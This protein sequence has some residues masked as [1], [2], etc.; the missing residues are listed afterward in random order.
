MGCFNDSFSSWNNTSD[1][2]LDGLIYNPTDG[3]KKV[4]M[5]WEVCMEVCNERGFR[6]AGLKDGFQCFCGDRINRPFA[7]SPSGCNDPCEGNAQQKCGT[8]KQMLV[9]T[10]TCSGVPK[11]GAPTALMGTC[12]NEE[13]NDFKW[14][15]NWPLFTNPLVGSSICMTNWKGHC[16]A[17][18]TAHEH[19]RL[20][21]TRNAAF[22]YYNKTGNYLALLPER[23]FH[24]AINC[25][26]GEGCLHDGSNL[27]VSSPSVPE[28][29]NTQFV[30]VNGNTPPYSPSIGFVES[31]VSQQQDR[32]HQCLTMSCFTRGQGIASVGGNCAI[33]ANVPDAQ[34]CQMHC[35]ELG[36][37]EYWTYHKES[38]SCR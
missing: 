14:T 28:G 13:I 29:N 31:V 3:E 27:L 17:A 9:L 12:H 26:F 8:A 21:V 11:G 25:A 37:C 20:V 5:T 18:E 7:V 6:Y 38:K 24:I 22:W 4:Q 16:L 10:Y 34:A 32:Q 15:F 23:K 19:A 2:V 36:C 35:Q 30:V 33:W 1:R